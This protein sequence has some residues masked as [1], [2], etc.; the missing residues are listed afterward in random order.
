MPTASIAVSG[1]IQQA[2][3]SNPQI[4]P[5]LLNYAAPVVQHSRVNLVNGSVDVSV[6]ASVTAILIVPPSNNTNALTLRRESGDPNGWSLSKTM[7]TL[8]SLDT[9]QAATT[10]RL[11]S[12]AAWTVE[13][14]FL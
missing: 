5:F 11:S 14:L 2:L 3:I 10:F 1:N 12:T 7:P 9:G 4:G 13:I 8:L 6:P